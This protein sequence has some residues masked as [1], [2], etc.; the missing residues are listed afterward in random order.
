[1]PAMRVAASIMLFAAVVHTAGRDPAAVLLVYLAAVTPELWRTDVLER[2]LPN[3]IVL[4]GYAVALSALA[5]RWWT[6]SDAPVVALGSGVAYG[7][8]LLVL[9]VAGG[10]GMGDVKLAG[11]LGLA[12]GL[13]GPVAALASPVFAF[14]AGG[15]VAAVQLIRGRSGTSIPFG[16]YLLA[17][18]WLALLLSRDVSS[19]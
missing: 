16:P 18:F 4:P 1:M 10:M 5:A 15:L 11:V 12:S 17:G 6:T 14:V 8:F 13:L 2:R 3:R 9:S 7:G 19:T